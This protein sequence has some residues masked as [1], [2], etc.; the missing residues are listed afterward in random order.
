MDDDNSVPVNNICED[1]T[2]SSSITREIICTLSK[3]KTHAFFFLVV[4]AAL[5]VCF[6]DIVCYL[7]QAESELNLKI[8]LLF[9]SYI[10]FYIYIRLQV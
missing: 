5:M 6:L 10:N 4:S 7:Y 2:S 3:L 9:I 8:I 1:A